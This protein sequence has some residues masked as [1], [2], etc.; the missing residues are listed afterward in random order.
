ML[1][2]LPDWTGPFVFFGAMLFCLWV[3]SKVFP[4]R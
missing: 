1:G 2:L 3:T 4:D